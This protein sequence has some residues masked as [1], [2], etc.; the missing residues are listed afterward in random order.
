MNIL[1]LVVTARLTATVEI[2][3]A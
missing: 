3:T 2:Q 1:P